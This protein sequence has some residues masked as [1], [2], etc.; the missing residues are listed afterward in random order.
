METIKKFHANEYKP[1]KFICKVQIKGNRKSFYGNTED[2]AISKA[3]LWYEDEIQS[4]ENKINI[5]E[6]QP[7]SKDDNLILK[8]LNQI[9][10]LLKE[11]NRTFDTDDIYI[12][13]KEA[14]EYLRISQGQM[15]S[16]I[17]QPDFPRQKIGRTYRI[18]FGELKDY[19]KKHRFSQIEV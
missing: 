1:G 16:L 19:M 15:Y 2:E 12:T 4:L 13:V 3:R 11:R 7:S 17:N 5:E 6:T 14:R 10:D 8:Q 9:G 18:H